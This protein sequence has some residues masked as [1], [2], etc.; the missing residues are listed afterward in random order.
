MES[1]L[2]IIFYYILIPL[3]VLGIA[4]NIHEF[5]H[6]IVA[7][8]FRMRIEALRLSIHHNPWMAIA[9]APM[10]AVS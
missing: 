5:G 4:V 6:F 7:K 8:L 10:R 2:N 3:L 9:S 1:V